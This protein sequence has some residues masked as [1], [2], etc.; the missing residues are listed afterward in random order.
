MA[1]LFDWLRG[2]PWPGAASS[3]EPSSR[4]S[5]F[6]ATRLAGHVGT[7][8]RRL[9]RRTPRRAAGGDGA[10]QD[11]PTVKALYELPAPAKLNLFLHVVGRRA[12][13]YHLLQSVFV[14]IDWCDT[15]HVERRSDGRLARHDLGA[16]LPADDLCLRAARALQRESGTGFGADISI[17]K[18]LP[19]GAGM[20]G[21]SS[22]AA[23]TLL[24]AESP[25]AAA[26][27]AATPARDRTGAGRR[28]AVLPRREQRVRR[29]H[30]RAADPVHLPRQWLAV[31]QA[32]CERRDA[33]D[34]RQ[35]A[36][37]SRQPAL[38]YLRA[39]LQTQARAVALARTA[40]G[41]TT[42]SR[43]RRASVARS[44]KPVVGSRPVSAT[45]A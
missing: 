44:P 43:R 19:A 30:R 37:G 34:L 13:G 9:H 5:G 8:R 3:A 28:R 20:G 36:A 21:G 18:R 24:G 1:A 41:A 32:R 38:L 16:A 45:A 4:R 17:V 23:T 22:D 29:R 27:A 33:R 40:S 12:D 14:L 39:F 2:R 42:C 10:R 15:L 11:G 25:V 31:D 35:P 6:R 26:L 7:L